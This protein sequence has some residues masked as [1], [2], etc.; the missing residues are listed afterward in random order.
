M[1]FLS[2]KI[3]F[4]FEMRMQ[5]SFP[6]MNLNEGFYTT[7]KETRFIKKEARKSNAYLT[8][9]EFDNSKFTL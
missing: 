6:K 3:T 4:L 9:S 7:K 2:K 5:N 1:R 8:E